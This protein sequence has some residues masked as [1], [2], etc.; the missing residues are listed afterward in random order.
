VF[1]PRSVVQHIHAGSS[2]EWSP[3]FRYHV[4][5]NYRLNG[6]KN[7]ALPQM[8]FLLMLLPYAYLRRLI[9]GGISVR[10]QLRGVPLNTMSPAQ[11][12]L[13]ALGDAI[14]MVPGILFNRVKTKFRRVFIK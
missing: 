12:E 3:G 6:I 13:K 10:H 9:H 7:A 2:V 8:L 11:I 4:T 14:S 5:R 1:E